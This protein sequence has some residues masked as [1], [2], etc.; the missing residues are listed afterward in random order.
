MTAPAK[1]LPRQ[2]FHLNESP[3]LG[4]Q[5]PPENSGGLVNTQNFGASAR[6]LIQR[7]DRGV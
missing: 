7:S 1:A 3:G 6:L 5:L 2:G 4:V